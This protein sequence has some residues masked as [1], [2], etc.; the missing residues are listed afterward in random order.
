MQPLGGRTVLTE[1]EELLL[2]DYIFFREKS[3]HPL[4]QEDVC[5][6]VSNMLS[7]ERIKASPFTKGVPGMKNICTLEQEKNLEIF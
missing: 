4:T 2:V 3:F 5:F 6:E 7:P 1:Y